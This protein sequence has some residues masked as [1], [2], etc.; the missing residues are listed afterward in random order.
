[1]GEVDLIS[2][3]EDLGLEGNGVKK[4]EEGVMEKVILVSQWT[5]ML[6]VIKGHLSKL[7]IKFVEISGKI[8]VK[9]RGEIVDNFNQKDRGA[10]LMLLSLGAGGVG[11]NLV[12][13]NHLFLVDCH[14]NPQLEAQACDCIYRVGQKREEIEAG[15]RSVDGRQEDTGWK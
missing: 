6:D 13:A 14:W 1:M 7:R 11:L 15:G 3:M 9:A 5:S 2:A 10:Q 4:E 12:G 8:P